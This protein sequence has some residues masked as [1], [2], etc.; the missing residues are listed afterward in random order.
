MYLGGTCLPLLEN[1]VRKIL[2]E[3]LEIH[4]FFSSMSFQSDE[5]ASASSWRCCPRR[6]P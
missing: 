5:N 3:T 4:Y 1:V 6:Q 2:H